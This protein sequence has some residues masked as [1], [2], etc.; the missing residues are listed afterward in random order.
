MQYFFPL[1]TK[2]LQIMLGKLPEKG[3]LVRIAPRSRA[4]QTNL[5]PRVPQNEPFPL[6][7]INVTTNTCIRASRTFQLPIFFFKNYVFI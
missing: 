5:G 3:M 7:P 2:T 4:E 1:H 6:F